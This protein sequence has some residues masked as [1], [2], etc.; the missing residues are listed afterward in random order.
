MTGAAAVGP[1][2]LVAWLERRTP[3]QPAPA[4]ETATPRPAPAVGEGVEASVAAYCDRAGMPAD[5]P[6]RLA[7][8]AV[9]AVADRLDD[10]ASRVGR[11]AAR[12]AALGAAQ[13]MRTAA[14]RLVREVRWHRGLL[15]T[16][17]L[18]A[19]AGGGWWAGRQMPQPTLAGRLSAAQAE[20]LRW[21][22]LGVLLES[23]ARQSAQ[24]G[25]EW[26]AFTQGWW[27]SPPPAPKAGR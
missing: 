1:G 18:L 25:R 7:L 22:D 20:T 26:C 13:E 19:A 6:V 11:E 3:A 21:N 24:A 16:A 17:L 2:R 4:R 12:Q 15:L 5:E 8:V 10:A 9:A 14:A 23:C 27:L